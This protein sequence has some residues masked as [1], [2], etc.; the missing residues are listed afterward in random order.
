MSNNFR[1]LF[2]YFYFKTRASNETHETILLFAICLSDEFMVDNILNKFISNVNKPLHQVSLIHESYSHG[3]YGIDLLQVA[4]LRGRYKIFH[5]IWNYYDKSHLN[6]QTIFYSGYDYCIYINSFSFIGSDV[7]TSVIDVLYK[8]LPCGQD[9][10][11]QD[12]KD[13][14]TLLINHNASILEDI[15]PETCTPSFYTNIKEIMQL[16]IESGADPDYICKN[17]DSPTII[18]YTATVFSTSDFHD[19]INY[20]HSKDKL[21]IRM[22]LEKSDKRFTK[23][24]YSY[25]SLSRYIENHIPSKEIL[26]LFQLMDESIFLN[27]KDLAS[28]PIGVG[29]ISRKPVDILKLIMDYQVN[30]QET[31]TNSVTPIILSAQ[32]QNIV[33]LRLFVNLSSKDIE[34]KD[35][36][37][38]TALFIIA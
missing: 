12:R 9:N 3:R 7:V 1:N 6:Y 35:K 27:D 15:V 5:L 19:F 14:T 37:G 29:I 22:F 25:T 16:Y 38:E 10:L 8:A 13:I 17:T 2:D 32:Q 23:D 11:N 28:S 21:S 26:D 24:Y 31:G 36:C 34:R 30:W 4:A 33:S 20:M 18:H